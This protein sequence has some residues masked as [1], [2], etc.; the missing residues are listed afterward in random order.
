MR[1]MLANSVPGMCMDFEQEIL[2]VTLDL[3]LHT[4]SIASQKLSQL[5]NLQDCTS[6]SI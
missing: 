6:I 5:I 4:F 1:I 2:S 3:E